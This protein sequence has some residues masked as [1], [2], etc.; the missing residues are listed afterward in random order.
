MD[1]RDFLSSAA[2]LAAVS[3]AAAAA[4]PARAATKAAPAA[5]TGLKG[6]LLDLSTQ[7]GCRE[8]WA[9]LAG[10][11]D[12]KSTKYGWYNGIVQGVR[13]AILGVVLAT[14][15]VEFHG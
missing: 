8:A 12:M 10:N 9:R 1:R 2:T 7:R 3:G 6:P 13:H 5:A 11:T 4:A 14:S 15:I